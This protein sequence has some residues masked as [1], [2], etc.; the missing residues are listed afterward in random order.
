MEE[1]DDEDGK[2]SFFDCGC[3]IVGLKTQQLAH[4]T[5]KWSLIPNLSLLV[6]IWTQLRPKNTR[7]NPYNRVHSTRL[8]LKE[9]NIN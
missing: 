2:N 5:Q 3:G 4:F 7:T 9:K 8:D 1:E 6:S